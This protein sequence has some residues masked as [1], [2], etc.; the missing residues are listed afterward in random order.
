MTMR[1]SIRKLKRQIE[2]AAPKIRNIMEPIPS[3]SVDDWESL[4]QQHHDKVLY[5]IEAND[6]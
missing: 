2:T 1:N 3:L 4:S 6:A 5:G